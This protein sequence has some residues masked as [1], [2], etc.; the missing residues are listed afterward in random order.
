MKYAFLS[1]VLA[2]FPV[3]AAP[4]VHTLPNGLTVI[5]EEMDYTRSVAVVVQYRVGARNETDSLAGISHFTEHMLFNGTP[6]MP[7]TTFWQIVKK[8]GGMA[9]GGTGED[10]T[11]YYLNFPAGRLAEALAIESDRMRNCPMD[12][13]TVA[14]EIGVVMDEWRLGQ[15]S[16]D[17]A[18]W[19][20]MSGI[21][22]PEHPYRRPV[23]GYGETISAYTAPEV[24]DYY[25]TWYQPGNAVLVIAGDI[26]SGE[27][28]E[29]V[30][31]YFGGIP[32]GYAPEL[33]LP[34]DPA[35]GGPVRQE[36]VF[37]AESARLMI[38]FQGPGQTSPDIPALDFIAAYLSSGRTS[39]LENTLVL[40]GMASGAWAYAPGSID[41]SPFAITAVLQEGADPDSV[42]SIVLEEL[43]LLSTSLL[44]EETLDGIKRRFEAGQILSSDSPVGVAWQRA[45]YWNLAGD[46]LY[47]E[48]YLESFSALTAEDI[49][50]AAARYFSPENRATV[51]LLP[52]GGDPAAATG[53]DIHRELAPPDDLDWEGLAITP[54]DLAPPEESASEG[55]S[56]FTLENGLTLLVREDHT[57]P[58]VEL[59]FS[60]PMGDRRNPPELAGLA[61][62]T[63]ETM[64]GGT[65]ELDR[66]SFHG[67][68]EN[69]GAGI[70]IIPGDAFT[71]GN[72]W[73]LSRDAE[74]L[75]T[76]AADVLIRPA[77]RSGDFEAARSRAAGRVRTS[78]EDPMGMVFSRAAGV[79]ETETSARTVTLESLERITAGDVRE[80][81]RIC[82]RPSE[83]VI[84][85]VG[86]ITPERALELV[87]ADFSAWT[88]PEEEVPE[89]AEYGFRNVAGDTMTV[90]IP[91][92]IQA[93]AAVMCPAPGLD[94]PDEPA[95]DMASRILGAGISSRLGRY[96][97]E[98]QGLAYAVW[99]YSDA[100]YTGLRNTAVFTAVYATGASLNTRALRSVQNECERLA[101]EG[102]EEIELQVEQSRA[103]GSHA[104]SFDTY[105]DL[106][107]Y[108]ARV[109]SAGLPLDWDVQRLRLISGLAPE[110]VRRAAGRY[111]TGKW[112][113]FAAGGIGGDLE[114]VG[115]PPAEGSAAGGGS[116]AP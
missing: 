20:A 17:Q 55:V 59:V 39:W 50:D 26:D 84:A 63:G 97:R 64:L 108:L 22:H 92:R 31:E 27:V 71:T 77:M 69:V 106:A 9:N 23:I 89:P 115:G 103:M 93:S 86:D 67:R 21:M 70:R 32:E 99:G 5:T 72:V 46:P 87:G 35:L 30:E 75:F 113:V 57:F 56:R 98:Q 105:G 83:T 65:A 58:I 48:K 114:P 95:F 96:I 29:L 42:E 60:F 1:A 2:L 62:L 100:Q 90:Y 109:E 110:D 76:S 33:N 54:G 81:R 61:A 25:D 43:E 4:E 78:M 85:V 16:P 7:N 45:Y 74:I 111:F 112:F 13:A 37:P 94:S 66:P 3:F 51:V 10:H 40:P 107:E 102:V 104:L 79:I 28:M 12:S 73:G 116:P 8:N 41:P 82:A 36:L 34:G 52:G 68:L 11:T 14:D 18:I 49:R 44:D 6:S 101:G 24:R 38:G 53:G 15:D 91:G 19:Q 80:C 47:H 88:D